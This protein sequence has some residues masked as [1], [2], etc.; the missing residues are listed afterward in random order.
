[1]LLGLT[2][3]AFG[4]VCLQPKI[5]LGAN[6]HVFADQRTIAGIP[7]A[8]D[9]LSNALFLIVGVWGLKFLLEPGSRSSFLEKRERLPYVLFFA[10]VAFTGIGSAYYHLAPS[11]SRLPW[12]LLP[13]TLSFMSLLGATIVERVSPQVELSLLPALVVLGIASVLVWQFGEMRGQ[14]DYR[15]YLFAQFFP[16]I[17]IATVIILFPPRYT[18]TRDLFVGFVLYVLA[19]IVEFLDPQIYGLDRIVSGHTLKHLS[20]GVACYWVLRMLMLR[21]PTQKLD[22]SNGALEFANSTHVS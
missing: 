18:H 7:R 8:L 16:A 10:G 22:L 21:R 14:G 13:M 1:M 9:V 20:A 4:A 17:A 12:D 11:D 15:F 5:P 19:K 6:Y 3:V 2:V